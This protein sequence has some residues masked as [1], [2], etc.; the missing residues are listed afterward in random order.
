MRLAITPGEPAGIGPDLLI[1]LA[2]QSRD[3]E[4]VAL[5]DP[6][7]LRSRADQLGLPLTLRDYQPDTPVT[8]DAGG[9]LCVHSHPLGGSA[10]TPGVLNPDNAA[11]VLD[12]LDTAIHGCLSEEFSGMIT[13]PVQKSVINDAGFAFTGHTE[14]IA[15]LTGGLPV[16]ML[17]ARDF[18]VALITTHLP[19]SQVADAITQELIITIIGI[20]NDDLK[21]FFGIE[22]PA[23]IVCGLNP[24]A[25]EGGHLGNE[26]ITTIQPALDQCRKNGLTV[27]G[28]LPADTL[29]TP[30]Y[31]D[32]ADIA[33]AMF[34]DQGLPVLKYAGFGEAVNITLGLPIVRTSVDHG[35][36]LDLAGT[37]R[38]APGSFAQAIR[39]A[40]AMAHH[41]RNAVSL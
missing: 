13:G 21:R 4:W 1:T 15:N 9:T 40:K 32:H 28:P 23:I 14:Y 17:M 41:R 5:C 37:G 18:R 19:L 26:E 22:Q 36:A 31:L 7:L 33:V 11:Y 38:A 12:T 30:K 20:I 34:H 29:F 8:A 2:Q 24:H 16:M 3:D 27:T 39:Q 10:V 6:D 25:G 35:T